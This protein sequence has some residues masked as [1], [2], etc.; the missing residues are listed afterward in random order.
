MA[1][2]DI[3]TFKLHL[4][5]RQKEKCIHQ[6][7]CRDLA[8]ALCKSTGVYLGGST[9]Q[10]LHILHSLFTLLQFN[11]N[12]NML[13]TLCNF[14]LWRSL[15]N[16]PFCIFDLHYGTFKFQHHLQQVPKWTKHLSIWDQSFFHFQKGTPLLKTNKSLQNIST[17]HFWRWFSFSQGGIMLVP[18]RVFQD[19]ATSCTLP[20]F[21]QDSEIVWVARLTLALLFFR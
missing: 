5:N 19:C 17:N 3:I 7:E 13:T 16:R 4:R 9:Y 11:V 20:T 6:V 21:Q 1:R 8:S 15:C 2:I 18:W 14:L 12:A 10:V